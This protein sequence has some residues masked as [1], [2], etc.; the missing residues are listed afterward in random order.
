MGNAGPQSAQGTYARFC[1]LFGVMKSVFGVCSAVVEFVVKGMLAGIIVTLSL[2][3]AVGAVARRNGLGLIHETLSDGNC[4]PDSV[5]RNLVRLDIE[6]PAPAKAVLGVY[7]ARGR[8]AAI[9][10]MRGLV[11]SWL[12][13]HSSHSVMEGVTVQEPP[14]PTSHD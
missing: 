11:A 9:H 2:A 6:T 12:R 8:T 14:I 4:C 3:G 1:I 5:L 7:K 10:H 13:M